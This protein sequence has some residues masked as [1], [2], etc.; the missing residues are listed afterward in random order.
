MPPFINLQDKRFYFFVI[1][2]R[3][4]DVRP[5]ARW[6]CLCDC[7]KEFITSSTCIIK[8]ETKSCGCYNK[9][10]FRYKNLLGEIF[11]LLTVVSFSHTNKE[12]AFWNCFCK[13][14][15]NIIVSARS[16]KKGKRIS[17]GCRGAQTRTELSIYMMNKYGVDHCSKVKEIQDKIALSMNNSGIIKHWKTEANCIWVGNYEKKVLQYLNNCIIEYEWQPKIFILP[18]NKTYRPDFYLIKENKW[19]EIK[20]YFR[21]DAKEKWDWFHKEYPNSELWDKKRLKEL[22]IL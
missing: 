3:I 10:K 16:L 1:K 14:G 12:T 17:C 19:I 4:F 21:K 15:N 13:C 7:G 8:G 9:N 22:K 20:G 6:K 11:G 18:N 5:G 2:E